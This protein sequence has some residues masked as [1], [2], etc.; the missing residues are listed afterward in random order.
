[1]FWSLNIEICDL[2]DPILRS[3]DALDLEFFCFKNQR[4]PAEV[5][6]APSRGHP[7]TPSSAV[8]H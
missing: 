2:F 5:V 3:G 6:P 1:M 4:P 8:G 7:H